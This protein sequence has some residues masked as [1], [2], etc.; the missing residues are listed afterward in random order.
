MFEAAKQS[1][2]GPKFFEVATCHIFSIYGDLETK[3]WFDFSKQTAIHSGRAP[4]L[5]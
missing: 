3:E 2:H 4:L 5:H 1:F